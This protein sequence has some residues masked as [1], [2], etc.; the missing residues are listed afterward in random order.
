VERMMRTLGVAAGN[1]KNTS[2]GEEKPVA[3]D[4]NE[5]AWQLNRRVEI[6]Y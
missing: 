3:L 4:H 5:S 1:I 6:M 2:Y